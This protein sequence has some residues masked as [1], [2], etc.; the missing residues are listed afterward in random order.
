M[1]TYGERP[2]QLLYSLPG[3]INFT[4]Q[5]FTFRTLDVNEIL[6]D[7]ILTLNLQENLG[8]ELFRIL[9]VPG[10]KD[11]DI[12]LNTF[13]N[14]AVSNINNGSKSIL[15]A[16]VKNLTHP[17]YEIGFGIGHPLIP[18]ELDFAWRLNYRGEN[19]FRIGINSFIIQ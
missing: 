3:N 14:V 17:F 8:S 5:N 6:G 18:L 13:L 1:Y 12:Q 10:L 7:R 9:R 4:S 16:P 11:W 15:I 2:Y 19:N